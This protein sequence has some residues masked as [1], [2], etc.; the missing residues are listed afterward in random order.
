MWMGERHQRF[1]GA[2]RIR[3][4]SHSRPPPLSVRALGIKTESHVIQ[5]SVYGVAA[6][7]AP[8]DDGSLFSFLLGVP[9]ARPPFLRADRRPLCVLVC[10]VALFVRRPSWRWRRRCRPRPRPFLYVLYTVEIESLWALAPSKCFCLLC[11]ANFFVVVAE[12]LELDVR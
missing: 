4:G 9:S 5:G 12:F 7:A 3:Q 6:H 1:G 2:Q 11:F 8:I 10:F